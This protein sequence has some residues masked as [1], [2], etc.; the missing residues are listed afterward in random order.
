MDPAPDQEDASAVAPPVVAVVVTCDSG[1]WLEATLGALGDQD[2]PNLS[3]LVIDAGGTE[4]PTGRVAAVLPQAYV[5]RLPDPVGFGPACNQVLELVEGASHYLFCHDDVAPDNDAVRLMVEEA[6]RSNAGVVTPKVVQWDAPERILQV[7]M[8][9]DKAGVPS[10]L[11]ERGELDQ[12]QHDAVRDVFFA[13]G[14]CT[15]VRADL[16]ASLQG[17]DPAMTL[18]G[19]DLDLSWRAQIAGARVIVAPSARVRHLEALTAGLRAPGNDGSIDPMRMRDQLRP[20]QLR[21]RLRTVLKNYSVLHL[22]R[23]VPQVVVLAV[24]ELLYAVITGRRRT[25]GAMVGAW[26]WNLS[27]FGELRRLRRAVRRTH[28]MPDGEVRRLQVRGSARFTAFLR[29]QLAGEDRARLL[30]AASRDLAVSLRDLRVPLLVW[31]AIA[32]VLLVGSRNLLGRPLPAIGELVP[33]PD[34]PS[35]FL[36]LFTSGW[37]TSG[38]GSEG[39][40]PTA[41]GLLGVAGV[42]LLGA[43]GVLQKLLVLGAFPVGIAGATRLAGPLGSARARLLAAVAY[44]AVPLPYNAL[45]RG[46]WGGLLAYALAPWVLARLLRASGLAPFGATFAVVDDEPE[47]APTEPASAAPPAA[48]FASEFDAELDALGADV[49]APLLDEPTVPTRRLPPLVPTPGAG[50]SRPYAR[51]PIVV[52]TERRPPGPPPTPPSPPLAEPVAEPR[53]ERPLKERFRLVDHALPFGLL[54]A[55]VCALAPALAL[56]TLLTGLAVFVGLALTGRLGRGIRVLATAA[57]GLVVAAVLLFPW[58]LEFLLPGANWATFTGVELPEARGL[59]LGALLRFETGPLGAPPF[60]W[61]FVVAAGLPLLIGRA[62]RLQWTVR[63]WAVLLVSVGV[64]WV[65]GRGWIPLGL[66]SPEVLLAPAAASVALLVAFGLVSFEEDLRGFGFGWR[67]V[68]SAVAA[69]TVVGVVPVLGAAIDGRW[70]LPRQDVHQLLSFMPEQRAAGAFRVLWLGDPEALPLQGWQLDEGIAY[71]TSRNGPPDATVLWPG[72]SDGATQLIPDAVN[73]AR[74]GDTS[75]LGHLLAPMAVRYLVV[76]VAAT[77]RLASPPLVAALD[78]QVDLR[79]LQ[80]DDDLV[81]FE[82]AA[83]VP[84]RAQLNRVGVAASRRTGLDAARETEVG[85]SPPVLPRESSPFVAKGDVDAG[86]VYLAE[87]HSSGWK[88]TV[89]GEGARHRKAFGWANAFDVETGGP[90]TLRYRTSV[91]RYS[92]IAIEI[93]LCVVVIRALL[94]RRRRRDPQWR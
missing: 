79:Q 90:A 51:E 28:A 48:G 38:L 4:D 55:V 89:D 86:S 92:A 33:F 24:G 94:A 1:P 80:R 57:G 19:E 12:E 26:T 77:G 61:A 2:Y 30:T 31:S 17:F 18:Y 54:L 7:G 45:A 81:V 36:R 25:A 46:R 16:F 10:P 3:V 75:R 47:P 71:G 65:G 22:L 93:I 20:L 72:S 29:G 27:R 87:A 39:S 74:R 50:E 66:P 49:D 34:G 35:T 76:P 67:Q 6:F 62:W 44:A 59:G 5:R 69:A 52:P 21:H 78:G 8:A 83:W 70:D 58:T 60:G 56:M 40:A 88:L 91:F 85:G 15:L 84:M 42:V 53:R 82:N 73:L 9:V 13:P 68:V 43:M 14:G 23:V 41:F 37:R 11:A 32:V 63:I 64:A